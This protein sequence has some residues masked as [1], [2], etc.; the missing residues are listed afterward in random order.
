V[1]IVDAD[2][3]AL[4]LV[5]AAGLV[6]LRVASDVPIVAASGE[7]VGSLAALAPGQAVRVWYVVE[8]GARAVEIGL[9]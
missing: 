1:L 5:T 4:R 9:E 7:R 2:R 6:T 8:D 3:G